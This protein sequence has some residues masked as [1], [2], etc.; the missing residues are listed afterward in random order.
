MRDLISLR[1]ASET[2]LGAAVLD[3]RLTAASPTLNDPT[4]AAH[5]LQLVANLN[6]VTALLRQVQAG[7]DAPRS[8]D[9]WLVAAA[10]LHDVLTDTID[11]VT[12]FHEAADEGRHLVTVPKAAEVAPGDFDLFGLSPTVFGFRGWEAPTDAWALQRLNLAVGS[13][14]WERRMAIIEA[15]NRWGDDH[16]AA[17]V[18][19]GVMPLRECVGDLFQVLAAL[20]TEVMHTPASTVAGARAVARVA[21]R[22][23]I[24]I[25]DDREDLPGLARAYATEHGANTSTALAWQAVAG[26]LTTRPGL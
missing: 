16:Q 5:L 6:A 7:N 2:A 26:L 24:E 4:A 19:S 10:R 1:R 11:T 14:A 3:L 25:G 15:V 20:R 12:N 8:P 22:S 21:A 17:M 13:P 23:L 18:A 9:G